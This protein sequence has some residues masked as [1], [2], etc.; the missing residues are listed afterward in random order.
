[1]GVRSG[2]GDAPPD[3]PRTPA[4]LLPWVQVA[5]CRASTDGS[6]ENALDYSLAV[7]SSLAHRATQVSRLK[8]AILV[9][10]RTGAPP[11]LTL[12]VYLQR[13]SPSIHPLGPTVLYRP[14]T[15]T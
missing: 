12:Y 7:V 3:A 11:P 14:G 10:R 13:S 2:W 15:G 1:M 6:F 5:F 4:R 9:P 8:A